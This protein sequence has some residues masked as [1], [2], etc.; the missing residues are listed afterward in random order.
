[1]RFPKLR[2]L[3]RSSGGIAAKK[4]TSKRFSP[5]Y[6]YT[7]NRFGFLVFLKS[8]SRLKKLAQISR[9]PTFR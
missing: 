8:G 5:T 1:M 3:A 6:G 9:K 2:F 4:A 7:E